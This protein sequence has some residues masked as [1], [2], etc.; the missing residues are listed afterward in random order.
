ME[1][2]EQVLDPQEGQLE[3][4]SAVQ[5][6]EVKKI[7]VDGLGELTPEEIKEY[8]QG[9]MRQQDY[10]RKTQE[11]AQIKRTYE[12]KPN[13]QITGGQDS[14]KL[15]Q[16]LERMY[17]DI[18]LD[19]MK[20]KYADFDEVK[21][22]SKALELMEDGV[23]ADKVDFEFIHKGMR[24]QSPSVN[25]E[26]LRQKIMQEIMDSQVPTSAIGGMSVPPVTLS[27]NSLTPQQKQ[28]AAKMGISEEDYI[29]YL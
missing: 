14:A 6:E 25:E 15:E 27:V 16:K 4:G 8:K 9:Y 10:T 1:N 13:D 29:K 20:Q 2:L 3:Q 21:V 23:S 5:N 26:A 7:F 17:I 24:D 28:I 19:K 18:Q 12:S 11:I 22:L